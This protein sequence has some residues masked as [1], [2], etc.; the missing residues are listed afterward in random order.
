MLVFDALVYQPEGLLRFGEFEFVTKQLV[1]VGIHSYCF[2]RCG[3]A[4]LPAPNPISDAASVADRSGKMDGSGFK[5]F[6]DV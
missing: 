3:D 2:N 6:Y 4:G 1:P 5:Q